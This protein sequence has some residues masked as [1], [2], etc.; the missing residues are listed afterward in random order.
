MSFICFIKMDKYLILYQLLSQLTSAIKV[1]FDLPGLHPVLGDTLWSDFLSAAEK[2]KK[3]VAAAWRINGW[4]GWRFRVDGLAQVLF[5]GF[6]RI[7]DGEET[8]GWN[9]GPR[10]LI[11]FV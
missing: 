9:L 4:R 7:K 1:F 11:M 8:L 10:E 2:K 5:G 6:V 3:R